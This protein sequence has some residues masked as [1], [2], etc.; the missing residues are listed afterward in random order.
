MVGGEHG[1]TAR[2]HPTPQRAINADSTG[3]RSAPPSLLG[4]TGRPYHRPH[5]FERVSRS[6]RTRGRTRT[7]GLGSAQGSEQRHG[8]RPVHLR[9]TRRRGSMDRRRAGRAV[10]VPRGGRNRH[11]PVPPP[12]VVERGTGPDTVRGEGGLRGG[13]CRI[14]RR[15]R[16]HHRRPV[17]RS[18][19]R[20]V[21]ADRPRPP[22]GSIRGCGRQPRQR[23][24][25][26]RARRLGCRE[27]LRL[28][29]RHPDGAG[30]AGHGPLRQ[31]GSRSTPSVLERTAEDASV[32]GGGQRT[33]SECRARCAGD[34][35]RVARAWS[36]D[37]ADFA[38]GSPCPDR[39]T[40]RP[41]RSPPR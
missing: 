17:R 19:G 13:R 34:G 40:R 29:V 35:G 12:T 20:A 24:D 1:P 23:A 3:N 30:R 16:C 10:P 6:A 36:A 11:G 7:A 8:R 33:R 21:P 39:A 28:P 18:H 38:T 14:G 25:R 2:M 27:H 26:C 22:Q 37:G 15:G 32:P 4:S 9:T 41:R 5:G 31:A